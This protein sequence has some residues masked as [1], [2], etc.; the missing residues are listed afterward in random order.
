MSKVFAI[1][2]AITVDENTESAIKAASVDLVKILRVKNKIGD[3][4]FIS[5]QASSTQDI[6][7]AYPVKFMRESPF[8]PNGTPFFSSQE[9]PIED[10]LPLCIRIIVL[11]Q[12]ED[13][14]FKPVHFY[15]KG[16][17]VLR[18]DLLNA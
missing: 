4:E 5:L 14:T 17:K 9:P 12:K 7:K 13:I 15:L 6:T 10:T 16:A 2:G 3:D 18:P 11:V 1:R 8:I